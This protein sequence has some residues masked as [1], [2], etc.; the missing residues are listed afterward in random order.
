M[1]TATAN[2]RNLV[3]LA[4][5]PSSDKRR[6]LLRQVTDLFIDAS[7]DYSARETEHFNHIMMGVARKMEMK[8]RSELSQR[9]AFLAL[10]DLFD[11]W[12]LHHSC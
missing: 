6:E 12:F 2:L 4:K 8:V 9:L 3:D 10:A 1:S 11:Q 5:E 7:D